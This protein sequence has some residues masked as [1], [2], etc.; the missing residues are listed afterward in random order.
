M[1]KGKKSVYFK[2]KWIIQYE[3]HRENRL[4]KNRISGIP[5]TITKDLAFDVIGV[6]Q[7]EKE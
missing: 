6:P 5:K 7:D 2:I 1:T 3:Q 4:K